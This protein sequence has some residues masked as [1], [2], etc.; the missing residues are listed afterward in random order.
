MGA[1][2]Q[3]RLHVASAEQFP[4][5]GRGGTQGGFRRVEIRQRRRRLPAHLEP[6]GRLDGLF[7]ALRHHADEVALHHHTHHAGHIGDRRF[8]HRDQAGADEVAAVAPRIGRTHHPA[9]QHARHAHVVDEGQ[10]A[11]GLGGNVDARRA[12]PHHPVLLHGLGL[13]IVGQRQL[14]LLAGQQ[15]R[16]VHL[17]GVAGACHQPCAR[18]RRCTPQRQG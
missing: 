4:P 7:F 13:D 16:H 12:P 6:P 2:R 8:V 11:G 10:F 9:V 1:F 14:D 3:C 18:L 5:L 17:R 15:A